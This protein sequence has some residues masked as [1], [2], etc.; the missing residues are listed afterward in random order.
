M[1]RG[2]ESFPALNQ[3]VQAQCSRPWMA[4]DVAIAA[5]ESGEGSQ[6]SALYHCHSGYRSP[7]RE[8]PKVPLVPFPFKARTQT[9]LNQVRTRSFSLA[10]FEPQVTK[11]AN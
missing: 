6:M 9:Y 1:G 7:H 3:V 5:V 4:L 11:C 8:K 2:E 10:G